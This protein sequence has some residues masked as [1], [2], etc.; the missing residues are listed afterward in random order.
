MNKDVYIL[1]VRSNTDG[2]AANTQF[3]QRIN[4]GGHRA[5]IREITSETFFEVLYLQHLV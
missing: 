1:Y 4:G 2:S 3:Q 5:R